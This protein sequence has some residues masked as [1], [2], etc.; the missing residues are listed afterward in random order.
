MRRLILVATLCVA[1]LVIVPVASAS[2]E[3]LTG[4]CVIKGTAT[5]TSPLSAGLPAANG[6]SFSGSAECVDSGGVEK[7][8]AE[9]SGG[10]VLAC[11]VA[12]GGLGLLGSSSAGTGALTITSGA[13]AG[14]YP[15]TLAFVAAGGNVV[16]DV[17]SGGATGD[18]EF[19][20]DGPETLAQCGEGKAKALGFTAAAAGTI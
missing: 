6:Y 9:V 2:A 8:S 20:T 3:T 12:E 1:G 11:A 18:A 19:L 13:H 15:F 7:G 17:N 10:G 16:L 5:F 4:A 14:T